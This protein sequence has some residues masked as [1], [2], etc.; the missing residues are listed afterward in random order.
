MFAFSTR[1]HSERVPDAK[2]DAEYGGQC[3]QSLMKVREGAFDSTIRRFT[4]SEAG[5]TIGEPFEGVEAVLTGMAR[6]TS[7]AAAAAENR[8]PYSLPDPG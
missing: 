8:L 4:I 2:T 3:L 1:V 5:I 6:E 7:R